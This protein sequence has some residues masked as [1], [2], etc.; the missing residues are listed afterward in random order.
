MPR[1]EKKNVKCISKMKKCMKKVHKLKK[2][3]KI[4]QKCK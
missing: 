1:N 4:K 3:P 2:N